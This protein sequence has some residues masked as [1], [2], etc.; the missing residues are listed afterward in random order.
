MARVAVT[1]Q[2]RRPAPGEF[3]SLLDSHIKDEWK[4][5][6][7]GRND[8]IIYRIRKRLELAD[9]GTRVLAT[10]YE[11]LPTLRGWVG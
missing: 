11:G 6:L 9:N 2:F 1:V 3:D 5:I 8:M 7:S 10:V 4:N